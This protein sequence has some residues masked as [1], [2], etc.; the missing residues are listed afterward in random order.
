MKLLLLQLH[1]IINLNSFGPS[2]W[3]KHCP[4]TLETLSGFCIYLNIPIWT[5]I[6]PVIVNTIF[7]IFLKFKFWGPVPPLNHFKTPS[8]KYLWK[9]YNKKCN[10]YIILQST[11]KSHTLIFEEPNKY[12]QL[13]YLFGSWKIRARLSKSECMALGKWVYGSQNVRVWLLENKD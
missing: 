2:N 3:V 5:S 7:Q 8:V 4:D 6:A 1:A 12:K 10:F 9:A 11:T 13:N